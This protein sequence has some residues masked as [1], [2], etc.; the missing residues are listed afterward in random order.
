MISGTGRSTTF[1]YSSGR[2]ATVPSASVLLHT[3]TARARATLR[4]AAGS[5][6]DTSVNDATA[7][8][9]SDL[10]SRRLLPHPK[11]PQ[12][13][14]RGAHALAVALSVA[15]HASRRQPGPREAALRL[16]LSRAVR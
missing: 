1:D 13:P 9:A 8:G 4:I 7:L 15:P 3:P 10:H 5:D 12:K 2:L 14:P 6:A 16:L 11:Y